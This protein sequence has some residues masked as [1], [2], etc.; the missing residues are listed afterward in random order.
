MKRVLL[1]VEDSKASL[2]AADLFHEL[3][4]GHSPETTI[5]LYVEKIEGASFM[6]EMLGEAELSTLKKELEGT[7]YQE[8]LDNKA[9]RVLQY[10]RRQ[11]EE[12]G[13][14]GI[15]TVVREGHPAEEILQVAKEEDVR[16]IIVG[17]RSRRAHGLL[18]GSVGREVANRSDR[19][20]LIAR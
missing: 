3:F 9:G 12:K 19:P 4:D 2:R 15:Q 6:D 16:L 1:A 20:V 11:L 17:A 13:T 10:F 8:M 7:R 14:S 5:L 18:M